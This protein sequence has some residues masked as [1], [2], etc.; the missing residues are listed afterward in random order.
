MPILP[1]MVLLFK[2]NKLTQSS[3]E[4]SG[5]SDVVEKGFSLEEMTKAKIEPFWYKHNPF[6]LKYKEVTTNSFILILNLI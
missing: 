2:E 6:L 4:N 1:L 3:S 5:K